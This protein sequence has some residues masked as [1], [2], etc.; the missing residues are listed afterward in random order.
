LPH[1][2]DVQNHAQLRTAQLRIDLLVIILDLFEFPALGVF[3]GDF[4]LQA[5]L[6]AAVV[7]AKL[8]VGIQAA[9]QQPIDFGSLQSLAPFELAV[10]PGRAPPQLPDI[11][12]LTYPKVS[13]LMLCR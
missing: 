10:D 6:A 3:A 2:L 9:D 12:P 1:R 7:A 4:P 13:W 5:V 8:F 11:E